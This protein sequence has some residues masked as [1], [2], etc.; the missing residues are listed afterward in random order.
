MGVLVDKKLNMSQQC[1]TATQKASSFLG[2]MKRE[3]T[4]TEREEIVPLCSHEVPTGVW[5]PCLGPPRAT[6]MIRGLELG[7]FSLEKRLKAL[8]RPHFNLLVH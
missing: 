3:M 4:G 1:V 8:G 5:H 6:E 2:C 7:L